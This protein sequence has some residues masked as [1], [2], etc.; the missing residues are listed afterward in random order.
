MKVLTRA[1]TLSIGAIVVA[2]L[3]G[4]SSPPQPGPLLTPAATGSF[5]LVPPVKGEG[6]K[7]FGP[8][9]ASGTLSVSGSCVGRGVVTVSVPPIGEALKIGCSTAKDT[10]GQAA[11]V[12][13][14]LASNSTFHL[15]VRADAGTRWIIA[16]AATKR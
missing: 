3:S 12:N 2:T 6:A 5:T 11:T 10:A 1:I 4:C 7:D 13:F 15:R 16:A 14:P 9:T 8:F